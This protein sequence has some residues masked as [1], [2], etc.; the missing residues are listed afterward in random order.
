M[1]P[2]ADRAATEKNNLESHEARND[3]MEV[4]AE[5][6]T[7]ATVNTAGSLPV[8]KDVFHQSNG[9]DIP[10]GASLSDNREK[11]KS[12]PQIKEVFYLPSYA[13]LDNI[14]DNGDDDQG[15]DL[16][17]VASFL[18]PDYVEDCK[19]KGATA[20]H[21]EAHKKYKHLNPLYC[22]SCSFQTPFKSRLK[23]HIKTIHIGSEVSLSLWFCHPVLELVY[24][25]FSEVPARP[26]P[27][28][29]VLRQERLLREDSEEPP[30]LLRQD[31]RC[32]QL[33]P[34]KVPHVSVRG[35]SCVSSF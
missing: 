14:F 30:S 23:D 12:L 3:P 15:N 7:E 6:E 9:D 29:F 13:D 28:L 35:D 10:D 33:P 27:L 25:V 2:G 1:A 4:S 18:C 16:D 20:E 24:C 22:L 31:Q 17:E 26:L 32:R 5:D 11:P 21:L 34:Q 19:F 8:I